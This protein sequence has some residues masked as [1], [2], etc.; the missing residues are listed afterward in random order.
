MPHRVHT[1]TALALAAAAA[2]PVAAQEP[3]QRGGDPEVINFI[4]PGEFAKALEQAK[5]RNRCLIIKGVAF[6]V[7]AAGAECATKGHW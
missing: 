7:D 2:T 6:G 3:A 5:R 1:L 4:Y